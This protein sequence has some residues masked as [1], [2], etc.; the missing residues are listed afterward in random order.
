VTTRVC[1]KVVQRHKHAY[2][3]RWNGRLRIQKLTEKERDASTARRSRMTDRHAWAIL[4]SS[5]IF[6]DT[7]ADDGRAWRPDVQL[8]RFTAG[9]KKKNRFRRRT[10]P[11]PTTYWLPTKTEPWCWRALPISIGCAVQRTTARRWIDKYW[12]GGT[13]LPFG[14]SLSLN[15]LVKSSV[16]AA[17]AREMDQLPS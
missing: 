3:R 2:C 12:S 8:S 7:I 4:Q 15:S 14:P 10:D 11:T 16:H 9:Q 17:G 6:C 5:S 13:G 1:C